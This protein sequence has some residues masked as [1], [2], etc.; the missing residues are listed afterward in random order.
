MELWELLGIRPGLTAVIGSG[1]KTSLLR[2]LAQ[3]LSHRG[4]VL[5]STTTRIM[6]PNWCPFAATAAELCD[7]FAHSPIVCAGSYNPEGKLTAPDFPGWQYAADFVLV[8]ADGSKRLPRPTPPGNQY[9]HRNETAPSAYSVP[10][11]LDS[12]YR[13]PPTARSCTRRWQRLPRT[14]SS[15][16]PLPPGCWRRRAASMCCSSTK[17]MCWRIL[18]QRFSPS[19]MRSPARRDTARWRRGTGRNCNRPGTGGAHALR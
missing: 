15:P 14:R 4:T 12:P 18:P 3:E 19:R 1:G 6:R 8:E 2:V 11:R 9:C 16:R 17:R 13:T 5:V 7:G 10:P